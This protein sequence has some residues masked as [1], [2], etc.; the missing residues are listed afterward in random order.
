MNLRELKEKLKEFEITKYSILKNGKIHTH[1]NVDLFLNGRSEIPFDFYK[2]DGDFSIEGCGLK[3]LIGCPAI[4]TGHFNCSF[5]KLTSLEYCP[6]LVGRGFNCSKNDLSNLKHCPLEIN[7]NLIAYSNKIN[8]LQYFPKKVKGSI[9]L[10]Q[11]NLTTLTETNLRIEYWGNNLIN[12]EELFNLVKKD[13]KNQW[14]RIPQIGNPQS[15][16]EA[17][18]LI[19][20]KI[21]L[22]NYI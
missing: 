21:K 10:S 13:T 18:T 5:N 2:I 14:K 16:K 3:S 20:N 8:S 1:Q 11:N 9:D 6:R 4:V 19:E 12:L 22:L 15:K 17:L 7:E